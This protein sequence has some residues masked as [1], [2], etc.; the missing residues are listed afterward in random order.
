MMSN[1]GIYVVGRI[2]GVAEKPY[3]FKDRSTGNQVQGVSLQIRLLVGVQKDTF[4]D[5]EPLYVVVKCREAD[6]PRLS[7]KAKQLGNERVYMNVDANLRAHSET[8]IIEFPATP[9]KKA[10]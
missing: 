6:W 8:E 5:D 7:N 9:A 1:D 4:G 10:S 2:N 3:D